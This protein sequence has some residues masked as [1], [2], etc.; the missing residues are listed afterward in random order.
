MACRND[1]SRDE[2]TGDVF[3]PAVRKWVSSCPY[4]GEGDRDDYDAF[5][6]LDD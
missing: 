1:C 3:C 4:E 6:E 2:L 5:E